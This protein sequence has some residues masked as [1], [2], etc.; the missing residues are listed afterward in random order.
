[1]LEKEIP[2]LSSLQSLQ[3]LQSIGNPETVISRTDIAGLIGGGL[4]GWWLAAKYPKMIVKYV[5]VIVGAELGILIARLV[6][7]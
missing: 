7:R 1:M 3:M 6:K 4:I 2:G 5:G